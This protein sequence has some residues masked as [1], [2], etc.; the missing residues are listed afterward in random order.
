MLEKI[1]AYPGGIEFETK[2]C[3]FYVRKIWSG[4]A[5]QIHDGY[6][7]CSGNPGNLLQDPGNQLGFHAPVDPDLFPYVFEEYQ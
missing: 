3:T 7:Y 5:V 6:G 4:P 1:V 2:N